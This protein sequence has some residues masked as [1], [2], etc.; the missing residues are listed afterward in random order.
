ME[1]KETSRQEAQACCERSEQSLSFSIVGPEQT[2]PRAH[3]E[4]QFNSHRS[5][6]RN[7][8][9]CKGGWACGE[10][11]TRSS[12]EQT[13]VPFEVSWT[14]S[15]LAFQELSRLTKVCFV[16]RSY[17]AIDKSPDCRILWAQIMCA[18]SSSGSPILYVLQLT[19]TCSYLCLV[20]FGRQ[21]ILLFSHDDRS[22]G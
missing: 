2:R 20:A 3:T 16:P 10:Y 7:I 17:S 4:H 13:K 18:S 8:C 19:A 5:S 12:A 1:T 11:G 14:F 22:V 6:C 21:T 15:W 9:R